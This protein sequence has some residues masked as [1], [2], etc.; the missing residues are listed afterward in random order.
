VHAA[1]ATY[2][3]PRQRS[4]F[5]PTRRERRQLSPL[6]LRP[7][8]MRRSWRWLAVS[9]GQR[10]HV[11]SVT[12]RSLMVLSA[13]RTAHLHADDS[14]LKPA[15]IWIHG[16]AFLLG[17]LDTA[18][19]FVAVSPR[20]AMP[21]SSPFVIGWRRSMIVC[22]SHRL[23]GAVE[24]IAANGHLIGVDGSRLAIGGD[25]AGGISPR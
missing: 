13:D 11:A 5:F 14:G 12:E 3:Q 8:G 18:D 16:G 2:S 1:A 17:E 6:Q 24:W 9:F 4:R 25:S 10:K 19:S 20:R 15:V 21:S 22:R 7:A 23:S